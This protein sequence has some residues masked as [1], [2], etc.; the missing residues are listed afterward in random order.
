MSAQKFRIT[1]LSL[2]CFALVC[3]AACTGGFTTGDVDIG[4][5]AEGI[6]EPRNVQVG[7][8]DAEDP[9]KGAESTGEAAS[10]V[11]AAGA[12]CRAACW[13]IAGA[14]CAA[15]GVACS[16]ATVIT[17]GGVSIPCTVAIVTACAAAGGGA[18]VCSDWCTVRF[19][20]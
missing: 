20:G 9:D 6:G 14:G 3:F 8:S 11:N 15:V 19:G 5:E 1:R 4:G 7:P 2:A 13:T 12:A 10:E 17:V 16:G 18:S